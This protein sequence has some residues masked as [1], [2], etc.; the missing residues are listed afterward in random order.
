MASERRPTDRPPG[1]SRKPR[2]LSQAGAYAT[3]G[4]EFAVTIALCF[5]GGF[6]LDQ[7]WSTTPLLTIIGVGLGAAGGFYNLY[8]RVTGGPRDD[9]DHPQSGTDDSCGSD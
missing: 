3:L 6:W 8:R 2:G 5:F 4:T 9:G 7:R 1:A